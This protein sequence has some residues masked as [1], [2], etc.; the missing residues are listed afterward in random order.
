MRFVSYLDA[1]GK[2]GNKIESNMDKDSKLYRFE[3]GKGTATP[4]AWDK[5]VLYFDSIFSL[6][7]SLSLSFSD[8]MNYYLSE[9]FLYV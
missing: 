4:I 5:I 7:L 2:L 6:S 9:L 3:V 8:S 1:G